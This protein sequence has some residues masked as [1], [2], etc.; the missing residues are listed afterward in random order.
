MKYFNLLRPSLDSFG[1]ITQ[2]NSN[3]GGD[4][5]QR[6]GM[7]AFGAYL[8]HKYNLM[9]DA[10]FLFIKTRYRLVLN[11]LEVPDAPGNYVRHPDAS[12]WYSDSQNLSK[13][14]KPWTWNSRYSRDQLI[15]NLLAM[16]ALNLKD[17]FRHQFL[18]HLKRG[19]L[20]TNNTRNNHVYMNKE[21]HFQKVPH[22]EWK[23]GWKLPDITGP[24]IWGFYI[25]STKFPIFNILLLLLDL[26]ILINAILKLYISYKDPNDADDLNFILTLLFT[27]EFKPTLISKLSIFI[28]SK[29]KKA[30]PPPVGYLSEFGP[31][32]A[33][34][35]YF[36]RGNDPGPPLHRIYKDLMFLLKDIN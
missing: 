24:T 22:V 28:Y 8:L 19:L 17:K 18:A 21:E 4:T 33:L 6:E 13:W 36:L 26:E 14:Y 10:E 15:P 5:S 30:A 27:K 32:T 35:L 2:I 20:F 31:Q 34:D 12:K 25:R 23:P 29:R 1:L 3:D 7:F 9:G 11:K 16:H